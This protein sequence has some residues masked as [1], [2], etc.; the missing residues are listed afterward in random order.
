M[1]LSSK[2]LTNIAFKFTFFCISFAK[3]LVSYEFNVQYIKC[4]KSPN[5]FVLLSESFCCTYRDKQ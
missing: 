5:F 1:Y 2:E 3:D 4:M